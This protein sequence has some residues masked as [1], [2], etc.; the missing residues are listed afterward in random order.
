MKRFPAGH[1]GHTLNIDDSWN[2]LDVGSGHSPHPRANVLLEKLIEDD[3]ERAG[4]RIDQA[5][6]RL[7]V[8]DACAMPFEPGT[9]DYAI[10]SH[11]AEHV[12]EPA[13]LSRELVRVAR[14][15]YIET[16]GWL[17][18]MLLRE[19]F[20]RWRV[21]RYGAGLR[22]QEVTNP[23]PLGLIADL[24]YALVYINED[25]PGHW[26]LQIRQRSLAPIAEVVKKIM[27]RLIRAPWVRDRIYTCFEWCGEFPVVIERAPLSAKIR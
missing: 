12:D 21:S 17:G 8:G 9:F 19:D 15:G 22:F 27:G 7:V 13:E 20:H 25:R 16:P 10:A 2:V 1:A 5:D 3:R 4:A 24:F 14:A 18:D 6:A 23:R 26:T 11:I